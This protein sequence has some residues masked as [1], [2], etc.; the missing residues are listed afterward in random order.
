MADKC[1][2]DY[3]ATEAAYLKGIVFRKEETVEEYRRI[4]EIHKVTERG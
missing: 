3:A 2:L 4:L 1:L